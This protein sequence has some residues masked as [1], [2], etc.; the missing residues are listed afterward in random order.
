MD[1]SNCCGAYRWLATDIC[2]DCLEHAE[3]EEED[4]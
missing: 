2:A 3:W 4:D 1:V